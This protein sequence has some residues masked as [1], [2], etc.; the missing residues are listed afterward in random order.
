[1]A[2]S[3]HS[4]ETKSGT[5]YMVMLEVGTNGQRRQKKKKGFKKKAEANAYLAEIQTALNKGTYIEPSRMTYREYMD[6][7]FKI[8][9]TNLSE[10][11]ISV[12]K[13]NMDNWIF[14]HL[15]ETPI[16]SI[17]PVQ[18]AKYVTI[19]KD[20]NLAATTIKTIFMIVKNSFEHAVDLEIIHKNPAAKTKL[21]SI[22]KTEEYIWNEEEVKRFFEVARNANPSFYIAYFLAYYSGARQGEI[23]GLPWGNVDF[24]KNS[25]TITQTLINNGKNI[26][27]STKNK[28]SNRTIGLPTFVMDE[29]RKH[30]I[31][32]ESQKEKLGTSYSNYDLVCCTKLGTPISPTDV[33]KRMNKIAKEVNIPHMKFHGFR[34]LHASI[35]LSKG[36]NVKMIASRLGHSSPVITLDV[37]SHVTVAMEKQVINSIENIT[38]AH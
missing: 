15:G 23:L 34:H 1:M 24:C 10:Q 2:G 21:P 14:P 32:I 9:Q 27:N 37:Y 17:T 12:N 28:S 18:L 31:L 5:R 6:D 3:I 35:L 36:I 16:G 20:S 25:I 29:L 26:S 4:Y 33:R 19:L 30:K 22:K 11:T 7:W 38:K 13:R 8:K